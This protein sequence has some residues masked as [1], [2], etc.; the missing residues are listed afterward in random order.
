MRRVFADDFTIAEYEAH[1]ARLL[2]FFEPMERSILRV[3][4]GRLIPPGFGRAGDLHDDLSAMGW[5][6]ARTASIERCGHVPEISPAGLRGYLYVA[7]GSMLGG[8]V[9]ARHLRQQLGPQISLT[10]YGGGDGENDP[11]WT[12]FLD[13]LERCGRTDLAVIST[14]AN[15]TMDAFAAWFEVD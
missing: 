6:V 2:G 3:V 10:F 5:T 9:I 15:A 8:Q 1:L 11:R 7:L 13:D 4:P 14:T 12:T